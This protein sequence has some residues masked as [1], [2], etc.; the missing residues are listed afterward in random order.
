M[1]SPSNN[2]LQLCQ[3]HLDLWWNELVGRWLHRGNVTYRVDEHCHQFNA[4]YICQLL[5]SLWPHAVLVDITKH[6]LA[7]LCAAYV[8]SACEAMLK[9][10]SLNNGIKRLAS[11]DVFPSVFMM[12]SDK[13]VPERRADVRHRCPV[14]WFAAIPYTEWPSKTGLTNAPNVVGEE[15]SEHFRI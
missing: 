10:L 4:S 11:A 13:S 1:I 15:I 2:Q 14:A 8:A 12:V 7:K 3:G 6:W 9:G 5:D